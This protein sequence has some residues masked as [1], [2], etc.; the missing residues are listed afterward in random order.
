[1]AMAAGVF[2]VP[3]AVRLPMQRTCALGR[4]G[5]VRA[6]RHWTDAPYTAPMGASIA[7]QNFAA[8]VRLVQN[9]GARMDKQVFGRLHGERQCATETFRESASEFADAA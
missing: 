5:R 9:S 2:P 6:A 7:A 1:M 8:G 3:P 4:Y